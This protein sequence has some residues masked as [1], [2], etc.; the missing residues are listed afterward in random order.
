MWGLRQFVNAGGLMSYA[1]NF[2][3]EL[4]R[5]ASYV[6]KILSARSPLIFPSSSQPSS[7]W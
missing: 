2:E 3:D 7:S 6:D 4:R 1:V 5:A